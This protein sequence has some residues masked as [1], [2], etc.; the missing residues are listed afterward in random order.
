M[1][2][3]GQA[4]SLGQAAGVALGRGE[5]AAGGLQLLDELA[6]VVAL[7]D[8]AG[9]PEREQGAE[10]HRQQPADDRALAVGQR[11]AGAQHLAPD[12]QD[13]EGH[14]GR[15]SPAQAQMPE[16]LRVQ[17]QQ[18]REVGGVDPGEHE[19]EHQQPGQVDDD[20]PR[21][22]LVDPRPP[23]EE[24]PGRH[25]RRQAGRGPPA[26][27]GAG[28]VEQDQERG[29]AEHAVEGGVPD[30]FVLVPG[31]DPALAVQPPA[32]LVAALSASTEMVRER[33]ATGQRPDGGSAVSRSAD[34]GPRRPPARGRRRRPGA[35]PSGP[36]P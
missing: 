9:D 21:P 34:A 31:V 36:S 10:H 15:D 17:A 25:R 3:A 32:P 12:D 11:P 30:P 2:V 27:A 19:P 20:Q 6:A 1:D 8:D 5:L 7:L 16:D 18:E 35:R 4:L 22:L 14:R 13:A 23:E 28:R 24:V 29:Q 33:A 26:G